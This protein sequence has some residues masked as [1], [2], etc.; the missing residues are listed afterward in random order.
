MYHPQTHGCL[1][2]CHGINPNDKEEHH[3]PTGLGIA[4]EISSLCLTDV[5]LMTMCNWI[6]EFQIIH[7]SV[8]K[9]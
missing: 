3:S 9:K 6:K 1:E 5:P 2:C 7:D 8:Q 4:S